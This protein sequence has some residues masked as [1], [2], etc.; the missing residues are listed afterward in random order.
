MMYM[1]RKSTL[2][3]EPCPLISLLHNWMDT[4]RYRSLSYAVSRSDVY[5]YIYTTSHHTRLIGR[6]VSGVIVS[7]LL[8][9]GRLLRVDSEAG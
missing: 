5:V 3:S 8:L 6:K 2:R 1:Y 7:L 4:E 9:R